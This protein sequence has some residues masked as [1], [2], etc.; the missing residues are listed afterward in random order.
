MSLPDA[1][2]D[3]QE[4]EGLKLQVR[5]VGAEMEV[6]LDIVLDYVEDGVLN[7][8]ANAAWSSV[9]CGVN[10]EKL[11]LA[12]EF[13][14]VCD[15]HYACKVTDEE[16]FGTNV[17][18]LVLGQQICLDVNQAKLSYQIE[19]FQGGFN[20]FLSLD[21]HHAMIVA[22][23]HNLARLHLHVIDP[24]LIGDASGLTLLQVVLSEH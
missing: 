10:P 4:V 13:D 9:C 24:E 17:G 7:R 19:A 21:S 20:H 8:A 22:I 14:T 11:P 6:W 16:M 15:V 3:N 1:T 23:F 18:L 12:R 2:A 5:K